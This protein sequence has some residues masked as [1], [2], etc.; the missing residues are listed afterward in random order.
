[1]ISLK[2]LASG[3]LLPAAVCGL[4]MLPASAASAAVPAF[5]KRVLFSLDGSGFAHVPMNAAETT[6]R[7]S[8]KKGNNNAAAHASKK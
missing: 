4:T 5:V 2:P 1:V 6:T 3:V 7:C 8:L